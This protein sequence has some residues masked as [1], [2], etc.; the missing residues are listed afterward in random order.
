MGSICPVY[1]QLP[2]TEFYQLRQDEQLLSS[3]YFSLSQD[4]YGFIWLGS[5]WGGG[6]YRFDGYNLVSFVI[7]PTDLKQSLSSNNIN[8]LYCPGD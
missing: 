8:N 6:I 1:L 4:D 3:G 2:A 5:Y 7:D